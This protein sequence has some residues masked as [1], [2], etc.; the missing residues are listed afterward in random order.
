MTIRRHVLVLVVLAA[1]VGLLAGPL[2]SPGQPA[3]A[4]ATRGAALYRLC[5]ACHSLEPGLHLSGPSLRAIW[6]RRAGTVDGFGRYSD[7]LRRAGIAWDAATLDRWLERPP[8]LVPDTTMTFP[9]VAD[10]R[11]RA[12]LVAFLQAVAEGR[13]PTPPGGGMMTAGR[14]PDL[15]QVEMA[16]RVT[17]IRRCGDA[18]HVTTDAETPTT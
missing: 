7:A 13:A 1:A 3:S 12:D 11:Q 14:R 10:P 9:G 18:Y 16:R 2:E 6:G 17:A 4:D 15:K 5:A 8:A